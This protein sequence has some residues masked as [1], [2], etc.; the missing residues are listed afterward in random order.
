MRKRLQRG[1]MLIK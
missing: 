1:E